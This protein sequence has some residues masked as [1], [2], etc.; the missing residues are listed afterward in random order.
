[1]GV[2][3]ELTT[4]PCLN[5]SQGLASDT[6][7]LLTSSQMTLTAMG[8]KTLL[9]CLQ[10]P[11]DQQLY[12]PSKML[13]LILWRATAHALHTPCI[14]IFIPGLKSMQE[15]GQILPEVVHGMFRN[16]SFPYAF[17]GDDAETGHNLTFSSSTFRRQRH[18]RV[19]THTSQPPANALFPTTFSFPLL[20]GK[21]LCYHLPQHYSESPLTQDCSLDS[22]TWKP[23]IN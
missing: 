23:G 9:C 2:G 10:V 1:M 6:F 17:N 4:V 16:F 20:S 14:L 22:S 11:N 12:K 21:T 19:N 8:C 5:R 15:N 7:S 18:E 3:K 13:A